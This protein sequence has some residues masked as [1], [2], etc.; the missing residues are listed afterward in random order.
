[1]QEF[2]AL[3]ACISSPLSLYLDPLPA[4]LGF[5]QRAVATGPIWPCP[6]RCYVQLGYMA[7]GKG[8]IS[9]AFPPS[10]AAPHSHGLQQLLHCGSSNALLQRALHNYS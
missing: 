7:G 10:G 6:R 1:M 8:K 4:A 5:L 9:L 2:I 3:P